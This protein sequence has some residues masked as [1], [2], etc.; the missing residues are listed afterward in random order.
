[1]GVRCPT[2]LT[3]AARCPTRLTMGVGRRA[4]SHLDRLLAGPWGVPARGHP[5]TAAGGNDRQASGVAVA[6]R[7]T[8]NAHRWRGRPLRSRVGRDAA[9]KGRDRGPSSRAEPGKNRLW[10]PRATHCRQGTPHAARQ[11]PPP[12][13]DHGRPGST[14][15]DPGQPRTATVIHALGRGSTHA[16]R[17]SAHREGQP[18]YPLSERRVGCDVMARASTVPA[19]FIRARSERC[20]STDRDSTRAQRLAVR[21][22]R[23]RPGGF[24]Q[25]PACG[26]ANTR[27]MRV[28]RRPGTPQRSV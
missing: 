15:T 1:M 16:G 27:P 9:A 12:L 13:G 23:P 10:C 3:M 19:R 4:R 8:G 22:P 26:R 25:E 11:T 2:R 24:G 5:R 17:V 14:G 20:P 28:R 18:A 21:H 7:T 6:C